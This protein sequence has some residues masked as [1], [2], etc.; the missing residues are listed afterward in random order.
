MAFRQGLMM[1]T[2]TVSEES[3]VRDTHRVRQHAHTQSQTDR[4]TENIE[5]KNCPTDKQHTR[6][7][8]HTQHTQDA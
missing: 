2:S 4:Q 1:M 6:T 3:L 8:V 7:H 5:R